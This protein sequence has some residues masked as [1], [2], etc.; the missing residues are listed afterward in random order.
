VILVAGNVAASYALLGGTVVPGFASNGVSHEPGDPLFAASFV[1]TTDASG[2][3]S[4]T[5]SSWP[6]A[7]A[8]AELYW[9]AAI[10][11]PG[12]PKKWAMTNALSFTR[13]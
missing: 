10:V 3:A 1:A 12:A 8:G 11:D 6:G 4:F 2:H 13:P 7:P 5:V 9:Q